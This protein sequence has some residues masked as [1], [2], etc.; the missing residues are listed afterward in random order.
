[1]QQMPRSLSTSAPLS[2]TNSRV[3][4]SRTTLAVN[5]TA[6]DPL[7]DVYTPRGDSLWTYPNNCDLDVPGSPTNRML[8]SPRFFSFA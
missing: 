7:P 1:M 2:M 3:S 5:P 6:L 4:G 8:M